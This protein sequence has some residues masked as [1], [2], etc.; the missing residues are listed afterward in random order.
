MSKVRVVIP[1]TITTPQPPYE[2]S[3]QGADVREVLQAV[4]TQVP[5]FAQRLFVND[6]L[7]VAV[8]VNG[9]HVPPGEALDTRLAN[10][11]RVEV[12]VPVAGG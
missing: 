5:Q 3:F 1:A 7:H 8:Y 2:A 6:R 11:D 9:H 10:G 12:M 4:A